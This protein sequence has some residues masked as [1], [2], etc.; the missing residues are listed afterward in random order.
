M[1][2]GCPWSKLVND[3]LV[4]CCL[5][6]GTNLFYMLFGFLN[7][8]QL[9]DFQQDSWIF[10]QLLPLIFTFCISPRLFFSLAVETLG[11][12][13]GLSGSDR[14]FYWKAE[15][16]EP[17]VSKCSTPQNMFLLN[18]IITI[19]ITSC[20][21]WLAQPQNVWTTEC[22]QKS[23]SKIQFELSYYDTE[24]KWY[25]AWTIFYIVLLIIL[26]LASLYSNCF[27]SCHD[28]SFFFSFHCL[29]YCFHVKT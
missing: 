13:V 14:V 11:L 19:L 6:P 8:S 26:W 12:F 24:F 4:S 7:F 17:W 27:I 15:F 28:V 1:T 5:S 18:N 9:L 2:L 25:L 22:T 3:N 29:P 10:C 16:L 20:I 23:L 21:L